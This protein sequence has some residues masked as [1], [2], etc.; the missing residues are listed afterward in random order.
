M[1][2]VQGRIPRQLQ[3]IVYDVKEVNVSERKASSEEIFQKDIHWNE[4][5]GKDTCVS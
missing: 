1:I 2:F 4:N 5:E 3:T